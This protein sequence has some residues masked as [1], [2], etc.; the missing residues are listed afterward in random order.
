MSDVKRHHFCH[1]LL[2]AQIN[3]GVMW[4]GS[5]QQCSSGVR[6]HQR[7]SE[8]CLPPNGLNTSQLMPP[9]A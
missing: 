3:P 4:E 1:I 8:A 2:S 7:P 5:M 9:H 6:E